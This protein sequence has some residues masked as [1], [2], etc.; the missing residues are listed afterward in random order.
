MQRV[1]ESDVQCAFSRQ[2]IGS[3]QNSLVVKTQNDNSSR[4]YFCIFSPTI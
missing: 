4:C 1:L 3:N 2:Y